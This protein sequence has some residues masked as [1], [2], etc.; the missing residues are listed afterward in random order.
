[1]R[2]TGGFTILELMVTIGVLAVLLGLSLPSLVRARDRGREIVCVANLHSL[3]Q[4]VLNYADENKGEYLFNR[5]GDGTQFP[6][7]LD[8]LSYITIPAAW[9]LEVQWPLLLFDIAPWDQHFSS[10]L[11]PGALRLEGTPWLG[12]GVIGLDGQP[13]SNVRSSYNYSSS[14]VASPSLWSGHSEADE[15]LIRPIHVSEVAYPANKVMFWDREMA[16]LTVRNATTLDR[17]PMLFADGHSAVKKL[18]EAS[19]PVVNP[20]SA[21]GDARRLVDT[22]NGVDG[23]DY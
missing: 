14:F 7:G 12:G 18:S 8:G 10:W 9:S 15:S 2:A 23:V 4:T 1:M 22:K 5:G 21:T 16:H 3:A 13:I 17:R 11:C 19:T 20:L 6:A